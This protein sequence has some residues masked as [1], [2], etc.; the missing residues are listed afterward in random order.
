MTL[1]HIR[2]FL[3][4][5]QNGGI[6]KAAQ[7]LGFAQP[8]VSLAV[9]ELEE[10]YGTRLF[11]RIGKKIY[12]TQSGERLY[13]YA[14]KI[15]NAFDEAGRDLKSPDATGEI[16]IGVNITA[17]TVLLPDIINR[18]KKIRPEIKVRAVVCNSDEVEKMALK[19]EIDLGFTEKQPQNADILAA[20]FAADRLCAVAAPGNTLAGCKKVTAQMLAAQPFLTRETGSAVREVADAFFAV[21]GIS[22]EP[23]LESTSTQALLNAAQAGLGVLIIPRMLARERIS[24]GALCELAL[25]PE[26]KRELNIIRHKSKFLSPAM[27]DFCELW[28]SKKAGSP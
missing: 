8:S 19:N 10:F 6:T 22:I 21:A 7:E 24:S 18:Y 11:D 9:K 26:I 5:Y 16:R 23:A 4:V 15:C 28:K 1:R 3:S 14:L 20:P 12:P 25:F 27:Q 13:G 17:G 2:I